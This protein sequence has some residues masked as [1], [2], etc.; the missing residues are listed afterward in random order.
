MRNERL[1]QILLITICL[2][3]LL[4]VF[5]DSSP[6]RAGTSGFGEMTCYADATIGNSFMISCIDRPARKQ[7]RALRD[8]LLEK[9]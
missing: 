8:G 1:T 4:L 7:L 3:L 6:A 2:L 9:E 5:R